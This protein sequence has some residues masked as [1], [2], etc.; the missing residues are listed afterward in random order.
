MKTFLVICA[1]IMACA[2]SAGIYIYANRQEL[3]N[4]NIDKIIRAGI[5]DYIRMQELKLDMPSRSITVKGIG[6]ANPPGFKRADFIEIDSVSSS[7]E[8]ISNWNILRGVRLKGIKVSGARFFLERNKFGLVNAMKMDSVIGAKDARVS[9]GIWSRVIARAAG[10]FIPRIDLDNILRVKPVF[11][12]SNGA[13]IFDDY[14][15]GNQY[16]RTS[17]DMINGKADA[18]FKRG[19]RGINFLTFDGRGIVNNTPGQGLSLSA[20]YDF[21][22]DR[23][24]LDNTIDINNTDIPPFKPYYDRFSPFIFHSGKVSGRLI[25][26]IDNGRIDSSNKLL[27]SA[28]ELEAKKDHSFNKFWPSGVGDLYNYFSSERGDI[29][30]DFNVKGPVNEPKFYP[31]PK[32]KQALTY[33]VIDKIAAAILGAGKDSADASGKSAEET[34]AGED[35]PALSRVIDII[36]G[37]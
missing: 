33:M 29:L 25:I 23:I 37:L 26:N 13:I 7:Y 31:G 18:D 19:Y 17:I 11:D 16:L 22:K 24:I 6:I 14:F 27:F 4:A 30:F 3:L 21:S 15:I 5:P 20:R 28:L 8:Q 34:G 32:T 10:L 1:I 12:I 36:K 35:K 2:V 9:G